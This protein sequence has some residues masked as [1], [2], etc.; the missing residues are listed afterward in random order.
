M[1]LCSS[2]GP[3]QKH[4]PFLAF[5]ALV[6]ARDLLVR[7]Q[8]S[9]VAGQCHGVS[10]HA[11]LQSDFLHAAPSNLGSVG[12]LAV[13]EEIHHDLV[14]GMVEICLSYWVEEFDVRSFGDPLSCHSSMVVWLTRLQAWPLSVW[15]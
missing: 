3:C 14:E 4:P 12:I 2:N 7:L 6:P 11:R 15:M 13:E 5:P 8:T 10:W 9:L 1:A